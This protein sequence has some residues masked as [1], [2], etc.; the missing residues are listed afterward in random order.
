MQRLKTLG[1]KALLY[2]GVVFGAV[3]FLTILAQALAIA[4]YAAAFFAAVCAVGYFYHRI[5]DDSQHTDGT[6]PS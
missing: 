1:T 5:T 6:K 3:L 2:M 4:F